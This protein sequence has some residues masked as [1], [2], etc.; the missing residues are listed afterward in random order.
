[1]G[2]RP[3]TIPP[4]T[5]RI[6]ICHRQRGNRSRHLPLILQLRPRG[7]DRRHSLLPVH[8]APRHPP[9]RSLPGRN[10]YHRWNNMDQNTL[11]PAIHRDIR[12]HHLPLL[13]QR[14]IL[15]NPGSDRSDVVL[16]EQISSQRAQ[17]HLDL[18]RLHRCCIRGIHHILFPS[19]RAA[20]DCTTYLIPATGIQ[21]DRKKINSI[22]ARHPFRGRI[23][24]CSGLNPIRQLPEWNL[25]PV[26]GSRRRKFSRRSRQPVARQWQWYAPPLI[27]HSITETTSV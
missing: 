15:V 19:H 14:S 20:H 17:K 5:L 13:R 6:S 24:T 10:K 27:A 23:G 7:M 4:R 3:A 16:H 22:P 25:Y 9:G 1:M 21:R 18:Y 26:T 8:V 2:K 11:L 12:R